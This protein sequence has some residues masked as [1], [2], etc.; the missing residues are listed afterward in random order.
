MIV[1]GL[2]KRGISAAILEREEDIIHS[3]ALDEE[4]AHLPALAGDVTTG[5]CWTWPG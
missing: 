2:L 5:A 1:R 3:M 4:F